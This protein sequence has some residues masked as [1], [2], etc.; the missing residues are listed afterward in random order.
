MIAFLKKLFRD[1]RGN[2]LV[3]AG[4]AL[5]MLVGAAGLATDTIQWVLWKRELQ[6]A[7]DSAAFAGVYAKAMGDSANNAVTADLSVNNHTAVGL[8]TGYPQVAFPTPASSSFSNAVQVT[9]SIQKKLGF[10]SLFLANAPIITAASTAAMV[11]DGDFCVGAKDTSGTPLTI[12]GSSTV[13]LGC[14]A[15]SNSKSCP[16]VATNGS[17]YS[18]VAPVV[19]AVGCLPSAITGVTTLKPHHLPFMDPYA[20][21]YSTTVPTGM[22]CNNFNTH[23]YNVGSG[24][25]A[26]KHLSPGC[27]TS[28]APNG[29]DTYYMDPGVYYLD[30]TNFALNGNDTLIGT[31][32]TIVLTGTTPGNLQIN[33]TSTV[34][35]SAPNAS[36]CGTYG[37][38]NTCNY[39]NMLFIQSPNAAT[40]NGNTINGSNAS[41]YDGALYFPSGQVSF[42][43]TS[44]NMTKC[45]MV[46]ANQVVFSGNTNLQN[47]TTGCVAATTFKGKAIRL[48]A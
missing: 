8:R 17:S 10:S 4:A 38:V 15:I 3:I 14:I 37:G 9:L 6:R 27:F 1:R 23:K 16:A 34:Q 44:G 35:I 2:A 20:G 24:P 30:S 33:G 7:A 22:S 40:N 29:S 41:T 19:E 48:I 26:V 5:P 32:V 47:N 18:F 28:F 25:T 11:D 46:V 45:L 39:K 13:N 42:T 21:K 31:G 43:G 36:N 12:G